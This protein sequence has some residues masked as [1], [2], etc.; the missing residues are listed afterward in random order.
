MIERL[1][2]NPPHALLIIAPTGAGKLTVAEYLASSIL[3]TPAEKLP[4]HP[5]YKRIT[6]VAGK[7]ISI[8]SVRE[9]IHF[10]MLRTAGSE[11]R[12]VVIEKAQTMTVQ[13]QNALL[14]TVE[15]PPAGTSIILTAASELGILPTILSRS[16]KLQL[17]MPAAD[18]LAGW[19]H[20]AGYSDAAVTKALAMSGG[21]PGLTCA[22]LESDSAHPLVAASAKARA[23]LQQPSFERLQLLDDLAKDRTSWLDTLFMMGRMA[24]VA[25]ARP[26]TDIRRWYRVMSACHE[27]EQQSAAS[28]Q[29][30]LV[31]LNFMLNL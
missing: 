1:G 19:F 7:S 16:Q 4:G 17:R 24:H 27:A 20:D 30:K 5:Y 29:T 15:E 8:D 28:A 26:T 14:K 6:P 18:N 22:L 21:L 2:G 9:I 3:G 10:L 23:I 13:A 31:V 25:L 12:V 11:R